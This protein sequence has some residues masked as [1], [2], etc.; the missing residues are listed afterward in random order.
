MIQ[1][2]FHGSTGEKGEKDEARGWD[3][4]R[5]RGKRPGTGTGPET[6]RGED[7]GGREEE[8]EEETTVMMMEVAADASPAYDRLPSP[9]S[10]VLPKRRW[11]GLLGPEYPRWPSRTEGRAVRPRQGQDGT[12]RGG[13]RGTMICT[14]GQRGHQEQ[15]SSRSSSISHDLPTS[16]PRAVQGQTETRQA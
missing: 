16:Y 1:L 13:R 8:E 11:T 4:I 7:G 3:G 12:A 14:S 2:T 15:G 5:G 6:W 9:A 10:C